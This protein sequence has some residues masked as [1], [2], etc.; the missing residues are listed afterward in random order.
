MPPTQDTLRD[1]ILNLDCQRPFA[2][3]MYRSGF[4]AAKMM[5]AEA[6]LALLVPTSLPVEEEKGI[7]EAWLRSIGFSDRHGSHRILLGANRPYLFLEN[8]LGDWSAWMLGAKIVEVKTR[9]DVLHLL[10]ALNI[11]PHVEGKGT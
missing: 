5:A 1:A 8:T 3:I 10:D 11:T 7:D 6:V 9:A 4:E 2:G